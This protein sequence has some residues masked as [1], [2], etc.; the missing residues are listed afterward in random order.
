MSSDKSLVQMAFELMGNTNLPPSIRRDAGFRLGESGWM[1]DD[2]DQFVPITRGPFLYGEK[3]RKVLVLEPFAI[4]KYPVTNLQYRRFVDA[5]GYKR[6]EFWSEDG[7]A[8]LTGLYDSKQNSHPL[9]F[10]RLASRPPEKR[11]EPV[12]WHDQKWNNP[13]APV[14]GITWF[15]A[16]AYCAW[17]SAEKGKIVRLPTEVE[18]ERAARHTDG[19]EYPWGN[20]FRVC[21]NCADFWLGKNSDSEWNSGIGQEFHEASTTIVGQFLEGNSVLGLSDMSGN[22]WEW[23]GSWSDK[24]KQECAVARGGSWW[25]SPARSWTRCAC[26]SLF[27]PFNWDTIGVRPVCPSSSMARRCPICGITVEM[28]AADV[29]ACLAQYSESPT[30]LPTYTVRKLPEEGL[31]SFSPYE[32]EEISPTTEPESKSE[33]IVW[34]TCPRCHT[35]MAFSAPRA[36]LRFASNLME[37]N[38]TNTLSETAAKYMA[39]TMAEV[40]EET[41][42]ER[43]TAKQAKEEE[44]K[45]REAAKQAEEE[46][47]AKSAA[48]GKAGPKGKATP[49]QGKSA[50]KKTV[51]AA[52]PH[53]DKAKSK[54]KA[55]PARGKAAPKPKT[56]Q[57][58]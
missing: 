30:E 31:P 57:R 52:T 47:K 40:E 23:T 10:R 36:E 27:S 50:P 44:T 8:W 4:A 58:N 41:M 18:W 12:G 42:A 33:P 43:E 16:E 28:S 7:R 22:V 25:M 14:V 56:R 5:D 9:F 38:R 53:P 32:M 17:L 13:L 26:R 21:L 20:E 19:R 46:T 11:L 35:G 1:P 49:T 24:A 34:V 39:I 6:S 54:G 2:L 15:E 37:K 51:K 45:T 29:G 55:K 3:K 48:K